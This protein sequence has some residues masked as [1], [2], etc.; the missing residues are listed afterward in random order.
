MTR[1]FF[2]FKEPMYN[3]SQYNKVQRPQLHYREVLLQL[4]SWRGGGGEKDKLNIALLLIAY[5]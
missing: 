1:C 5:I 2:Y 3:K 4:V